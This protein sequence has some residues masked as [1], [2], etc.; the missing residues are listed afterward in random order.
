MREII[1]WYNRNKKTIWRT[2]LIIVIIIV[3][4][5]LLRWISVN[6]Q[7]RNYG[8]IFTTENDKQ[9]NLNAVILEDDKSTITGDNLLKTQKE[10]LKVIDQFVEYC[11]RNQINE[12]YNLLSEECKS[13]MYTTVQTF[14]ESYYNKIFKGSTK[15]VSIENWIGNIYKVK[16]AEDALSTGIYNSQSNLQDYIT[17]VEDENGDSKLNINGYIAKEK[18]DKSNE[19]DNVKIQV[20]EKNEY[21]DFEA[22]AF[23]I[24]NKTKNTILLNDI[25]SLDTLYLEDKNGIK[26]DAY[27]HELS[28]ADLK[29]LVGETKKITIKY[30]NKYSSSKKIENI[31][32]SKIILNYDSYNKLEAMGNIGNYNYYGK[33]QIDL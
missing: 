3:L 22:Y 1:L 13:E 12:A 21:M 17:I 5:Q 33:I 26:Y 19:K 29:V 28:T 4:V 30:Y 32:F 25:N 6:N 23:E 9:S 11:N 20:V 16:F 18:I 15:N 24:T 14:K 10:S 8:N 27:M 7:K 31:T 2:I